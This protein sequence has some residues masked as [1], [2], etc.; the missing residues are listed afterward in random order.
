VGR[1]ELDI[2]AERGRLLIAIEVKWRARKKQRRHG[3]RRSA[4]ARHEAVLGAMEV[5]PGAGER[6]WRF[7]LVTIE[8]HPHGLSL[9]HR[10]AAWS[11]GNRFW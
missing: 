2:V 5:L 4:R 3:A 8:E 1:R 6:P 9:T 10:R 7:D 11:P